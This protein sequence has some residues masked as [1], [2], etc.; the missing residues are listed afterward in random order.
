MKKIKTIGLLTSGGDAPG[1]NA[2]IRA[3]VRTAT[4]QKLNVIGFLRGYR[5]LMGDE[6]VRLRADSVGGIINLGGTVLKTAR[7]EPFKETAGQK[8]AVAVLKKHNIDGLIVIGGDGTFRGGH[9]LAMRWGIQTVGI[10]GT[11]DN[12]LYGTDM[13]IGFDTAVNTALDA[14]DKLRDTATSHERLFLVEV[15]GRTSGFLALYVGLASG[16]EEILVPEERTNIAKVKQ[17]LAKARARGKK[18]S[19]VIVAEGDDA[20]NVIQLKEKLHLGKEYDVRVAVLGHIQR[21]GMPTATDR[22]LAGRLGY[23]AVRALMEGKTDVMVGIVADRV[24][25]TDFETAYS[26]KKQFDAELLDIS[27]ILAT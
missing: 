3:V 18:S 16:A 27:H 17:V 14:T 1:M 6:T 15:M 7:W 23:E 22:I 26:V 12:D 25:Y 19:I 24:T 13:T 4:Y 9:D 11:I 2:A 20:G 5:G 21:G 8:R 10:P